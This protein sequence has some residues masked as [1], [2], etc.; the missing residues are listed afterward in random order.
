[1]CLR[2]PTRSLG[3]LRLAEE[4]RR[5]ALL[6]AWNKLAPPFLVMATQNPIEQEGTYPLPEAQMDRFLMHVRVDYPPM[7]DEVAVI[8]MVRAE[9]VASLTAGASSNSRP[10]WMIN[11]SSSVRSS[12]GP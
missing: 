4:K 3:R 11:A 12:N 1:M 6:T 10:N 7:E 8:E 2:N 9:E 5:G